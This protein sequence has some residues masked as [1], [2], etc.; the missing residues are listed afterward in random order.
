MSYQKTR[1][2]KGK[3]KKPDP[4]QHEVD[5]NPSG[6]VTILPSESLP[7]PPATKRIHSR[8]VLPAVPEAPMK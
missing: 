8:R 1:T 5:L 4:H 2:H 6:E 3:K 7:T